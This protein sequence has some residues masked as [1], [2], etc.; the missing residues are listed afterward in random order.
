MCVWLRR[1]DP[2]MYGVLF[3]LLA[4]KQRDISLQSAPTISPGSLINPGPRGMWKVGDAVGGCVCLGLCTAS[5]PKT[6]AERST[7]PYPAL[8]FN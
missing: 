7:P 4:G 3:Q 1:S 6:A 8:H 2:I 5:E